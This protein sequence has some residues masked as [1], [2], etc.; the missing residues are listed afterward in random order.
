MHRTSGQ[1]RTLSRSGPFRGLRSGSRYSLRNEGRVAVR[2]VKYEPLV[3]VMR[4]AL[5]VAMAVLV[6]ASAMSAG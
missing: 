6:V 4:V 3:Y 2:R 1:R 5:T